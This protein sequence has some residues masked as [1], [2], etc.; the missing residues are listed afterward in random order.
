M[1][2]FGT[3]ED[4]VRAMKEGAADFLTKPVDTEHLMLLLDR[5]IERRRLRTDYVLL[6][7]D[8]QRRVGLP[9]VIG[10]DRR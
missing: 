3:I 10:D 4:A 8:Y 7:E 1:T 9:R 2:A 5:A 6:K